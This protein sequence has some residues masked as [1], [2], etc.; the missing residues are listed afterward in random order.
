LRGL[1]TRILQQS[2]VRTLDKRRGVIDAHDID[3]HGSGVLTPVSVVGVKPEAVQSAVVRGRGVADARLVG[4]NLSQAGQHPVGRRVLDRKGERVAL[5][6]ARRQGDQYRVVFQRGDISV[7]SLRRHVAEVAIIIYLILTPTR[8]S[9][10]KK[11]PVASALL[12]EDRPIG[13]EKVALG[14]A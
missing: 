9:R 8:T 14:D 11:P 1:G 3:V 2:H 13:R 7:V 5:R 12:Q 4:R 10:A 6:I